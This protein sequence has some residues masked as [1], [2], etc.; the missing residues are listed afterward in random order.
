MARKKAVRNE[1]DLYLDDA[2]SLDTPDLELDRSMQERGF[3]SLSEG[4]YRSAVRSLSDE[5]AEQY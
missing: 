2:G 1:D 5:V 3:A 4:S